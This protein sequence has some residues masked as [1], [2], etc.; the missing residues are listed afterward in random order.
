MQKRTD[1]LILKHGALG[2]IIQAF[3][4]F[5][6]VRMSFPSAHISVLTSPA[7]APLLERSGWFD[8][9]EIDKRAPFWNLNELMKNRRLLSRNWDMVLDFQCSK[10]TGHYAKFRQKHTR[11]FGLSDYVTD[12][13]PDFTS[14][15]NADR[16]LRTAQMAGAKMHEAELNWLMGAS[17]WP[18]AADCVKS[19]P[20]AL[21]FAGCS[22][23][24]PQKRWRADYFADI[25]QQAFDAGIRPVLGG[26]AQDRDANDEVLRKCPGALDLTAKTSIVELASLCAQARFVVG[27]DTGPVFLAAKS[28][29]PTVMVMGAETNPEMS[30]PRGRQASYIRAADIQDIT[31]D[32]LIEKLSGLK[33]FEC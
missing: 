4:A 1:I 31:P 19:E 26:T 17:D 30:A 7:F 24:K 32:Q 14:V 12:R 2:D 20:Y 11:W 22:L 21:I 18:A 15:N 27:N 16:M 25:A 28:D 6:S 29:T 8:R 10:R 9:V 33:V 5:A 3:D 23:A 13:L